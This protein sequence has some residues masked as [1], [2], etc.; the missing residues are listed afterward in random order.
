MKHRT[1]SERE[2]YLRALEF[3]QPEWIPVTFDL[4][5]SSWLKYGRS[6]ETVVLRHPLVF[7]DY[8]PGSFAAEPRDPFYRAYD[9]LRDDWGCVWR[10]TQPGLLG[11]VVE[12]PLAE[13]KTFETFRAPD[14]REQYDWRAIREVVHRDQQNGR[15]T[16]GWISITQGGFFDRLQFLRGLE[17]LLMDFAEH[18]P[19][20]DLLL[21]MVLDYNLRYVK[22]WLKIGV[23]Q[24]CLHGDL[25]TQHA[26]L[27]SPR[28][29]R[30]YLKPAYQ[31][32]FGACRRAGTHVWYSSDGRMADIVDD[33][34]ECGATLHDPQLGPNSMEEVV[35]AYRGR[36]CALVDLNEQLLPFD[37]P[38]GIHARI[39]AVVEAMHAPEGGLM[40]YLLCNHDT[41]LEN[42]EALCTGA[43]KYCF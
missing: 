6:L 40:L 17:N 20:L 13:W 18:P 36:L 14:P 9:R 19:Q 4:G 23:D 5:P 26:L 28:D 42:I 1:L 34:R 30:R 27:M 38:A 11:Q 22:E 39:R 43:E 31:A 16:R 2:N 10:N 15:L 33:L 7:S 12:H 3:R 29:F 41:P 25:G 37:T 32:L 24:I 35:A 21:E 8:Q